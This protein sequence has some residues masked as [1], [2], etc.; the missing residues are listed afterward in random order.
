MKGIYDLY[1]PKYTSKRRKLVAT[2]TVQD[3]DEEANSSSNVGK[4]ALENCFI[5]S[6]GKKTQV[7]SDRFN[8]TGIIR[9]LQRCASR[10]QGRPG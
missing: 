2:M 1:G 10:A 5:S 6:Q 8:S 9:T 4:I 3:F 7:H